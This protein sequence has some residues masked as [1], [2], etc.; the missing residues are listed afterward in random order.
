M[1]IIL[2]YNIATQKTTIFSLPLNLKS[3][4]VSL[5]SLKDLKRRSIKVF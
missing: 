4:K 5:R 3:H 1:F 2:P